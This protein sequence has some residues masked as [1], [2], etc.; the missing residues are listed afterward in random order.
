MRSFLLVFDKRG[1]R[2]VLR[3]DRGKRTLVVEEERAKEF[4]KTER[5]TLFD[6]FR[7]WI[8]EKRS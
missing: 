5:P 3:Q 2:V 6:L 7:K 4:L 1:V 8:S